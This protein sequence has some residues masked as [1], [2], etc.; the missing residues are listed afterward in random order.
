MDVGRQLRDLAKSQGWATPELHRRV[1]GAGCS[2]S[3]PSLRAYFHGTRQP[4]QE[5]AEALIRA[6][7]HLQGTK[8][9]LRTDWRTLRLRVTSRSLAAAKRNAGQTQI[10]LSNLGVRASR[11]RGLK[12]SWDETTQAPFLI[13]RDSSAAWR[14][15]LEELAPDQLE[16]FDALH[17]LLALAANQWLRLYLHVQALT[18][19]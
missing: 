11:R 3:L 9:V 1:E 7:D 8:T 2:V 19:S 18:V 17:R 13:V 6:I 15:H 12:I 16:H 14:C 5:T 10:A 4:K